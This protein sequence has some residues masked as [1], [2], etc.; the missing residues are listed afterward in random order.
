MKSVEVREDLISALR[1][2]LIGPG[3]GHPHESETLPQAPSRWYLT[4]FL[5]PYE[6]PESQRRDAVSDEQIDLPGMAGGTDD[7]ERPERASGRK[8]FLPSSLGVSV[9]VP[10]NC[11]VIKV[12][13]FWGDYRL[14]QSNGGTEGTGTSSPPGRAPQQWQRTQRVFALAIPVPKSTNKP[15]HTDIPESGGVRIVM[16]VRPVKMDG[17]GN[18]GSLLPPGTRSVSM[19]LVNYRP[20]APDER[21]DEGFLFQ[22]GMTLYPDRP[23]VPRPDLCGFDSDD[24]DERVADLQFRDVYECAVGHGV[25]TTATIGRPR[26]VP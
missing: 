22:A 25:A 21:K 20:T 11:Q 1:L 12:K 9:L 26:R 3:P 13:A 14:L 23:L 19:F 5:V 16:S 17:V 24:P 6:A 18:A 4:G 10:E 15:I 7:D 8:V 2:D